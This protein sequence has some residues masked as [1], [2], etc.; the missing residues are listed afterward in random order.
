MFIGEISALGSAFLW[1]CNTVLMRWLSPHA[2]VVALNAVR[3][4]VGAIVLL[5]GMVLF[6]RAP[7][8]L[9]VPPVPLGYLL[10]SVLI[11]L[12]VGDSFY[13]QALRLVGVVRA[14]PIAMSYPLITALL[15]AA[16]LGE[17]L[18]LPVVAGIA[19]VVAGVSGVTTAQAPP[20]KL[21]QLVSPATY[22]AG[23]VFG[24][25]AAV[26]WALGTVLLRPAVDQI[27][28]FVA[29]S[30]RLA[31]ATLVLHA[32]AARHLPAVGRVARAE[33]GV[34]AALLLLG[35]GTAVSMALFVL[36][37]T[38]AGAARGGALA[39]AAPLFGVPIAVVVLKEP[40]T[41]QLLVSVALTL[42]GVWLIV[43]R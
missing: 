19:L 15:A 18:T 31:V 34:G 25:G 36:G 28:P 22:R 23:I 6:G 9:H 20:G 11:G 5:A 29:A 35:V 2:N 41:V 40:V 7:D 21:P 17:A 1:A 27:D 16:F 33:R 10:A 39:S 4:L 14:Q 32:F 37:V 26:C 38:Y 24:L 3:C 13:F 42:A 30:W 12:G 8:L 43:L